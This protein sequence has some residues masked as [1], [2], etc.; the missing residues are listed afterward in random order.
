MGLTRWSPP[1]DPTNPY[2][3]KSKAP[4]SEADS[5]YPFWVVTGILTIEPLPAVSPSFDT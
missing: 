4:P 5:W 2:D 1:S 3:P